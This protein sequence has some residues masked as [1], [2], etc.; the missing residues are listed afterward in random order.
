MIKAPIML[1]NYFMFQIIHNRL[2]RMYRCILPRSAEMGGRCDFWQ[3]NLCSLPWNFG[4]FQHFRK[5]I[6][7]TGPELLVLRVFDHTKQVQQGLRFPKQPCCSRV[8]NL[9][10]RCSS[11]DCANHTLKIM[12]NPGKRNGIGMDTKPL[13]IGTAIKKVLMKIKIWMGNPWKMSR[14][15]LR[16]NLGFQ[17]MLHLVPRYAY[18]SVLSVVLARNINQELPTNNLILISTG[19]HAFI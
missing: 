12:T 19:A 4:G 13:K 14:N 18:Q 8:Q 2:Y 7:I 15:T 17:R 1:F 9:F 3:A 5:T 16:V 11:K 6:K 10:P